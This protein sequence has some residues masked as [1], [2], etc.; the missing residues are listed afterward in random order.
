MTCI[1]INEQ[2]VKLWNWLMKR[3]RLT[4]VIRSLIP[5]NSQKYREEKILREV[6]CEMDVG[7]LKKSLIITQI[8]NVCK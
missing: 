4:L 2:D 3:T 8:P 7:I 6:L 1:L 5:R